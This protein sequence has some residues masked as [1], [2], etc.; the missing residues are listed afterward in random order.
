MGNE[1]EKFKL[2]SVKK[3]KVS[4]QQKAFNQQEARKRLDSAN[5]GLKDRIISATSL[6]EDSNLK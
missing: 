6:P 5:Q 1:F 4:E 3:L 2:G